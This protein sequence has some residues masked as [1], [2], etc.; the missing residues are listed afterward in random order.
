MDLHVRFGAGKPLLLVHGLG[1]SRQSWSTVIDALATE[2]EPY[3]SYAS[4]GSMSINSPA[5][6]RRPS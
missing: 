1:G 5:S 3:S 4:R 6:S 2:R